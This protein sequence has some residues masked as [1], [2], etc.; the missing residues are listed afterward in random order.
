M[1]RCHFL[2]KNITIVR[3]AGGQ[4]GTKSSDRPSSALRT[5]KWR[6]RN[7]VKKHNRCSCGNERL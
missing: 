1:N 5:R 3:Q 6:R 2:T 7:T 4:R